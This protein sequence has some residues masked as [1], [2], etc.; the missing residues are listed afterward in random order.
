MAR[1]TKRGPIGG[2]VPTIEEY[3][4]ETPE[5]DADGNSFEASAVEDAASLFGVADDATTL[6]GVLSGAVGALDGRRL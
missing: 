4:D 6:R 2:G 1:R 5:G 3:D